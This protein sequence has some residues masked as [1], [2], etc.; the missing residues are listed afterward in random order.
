MPLA[1]DVCTSERHREGQKRASTGEGER[2]ILPRIGHGFA[3]AK[4]GHGI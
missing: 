3:M 1:M 2:A 4:P